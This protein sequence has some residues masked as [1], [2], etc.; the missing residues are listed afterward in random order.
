MK[1]PSTFDQELYSG[2]CCVIEEQQ[3]MDGV[4]IIA[5]S[6]Y[7]RSGIQ[8]L[9]LFTGTF[10]ECDQWR[11]QYTWDNP[12]Y[13]NIQDEVSIA[14][15]EHVPNW[16]Y[17]NDKSPKENHKLFSEFCNENNIALEDLVCYIFE[18]KGIATQD[19][20]TANAIEQDLYSAAM[21]EDFHK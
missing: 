12:Y 13:S 2:T 4:A 5:Y 9:I 6:E 19:V 8:N 18:E 1:F 14:N 7:K 20:L 3:S 15:R 11:S 21:E 10:D 17:Y 16:K